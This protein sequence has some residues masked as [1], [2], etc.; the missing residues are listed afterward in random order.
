M[1]AKVFPALLLQV[2]F[3]LLAQATLYVSTLIPGPL[4][5]ALAT[6][7]TGRGGAGQVTE[8]VTGTTCHGGKPCKVVWLDNGVVPLLAQI[9]PCHVALYHGVEQLVQQIDPVNVATQHSLQ[10][11]VRPLPPCLCARVGQ[12]AGSVLTGFPRPL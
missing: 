5:T 9:G 10:F 7:R 2:L 3:A 6:K 11:T 12:A 1:Y 4:C 8:P